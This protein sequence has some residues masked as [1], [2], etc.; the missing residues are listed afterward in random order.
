MGISSAPVYPFPGG[1]AG[2]IPPNP[3]AGRPGHFA[4]SN[5]IKQ[6]TLNL[7]S[8]SVKNSGDTMRG[9]LNVQTPTDP[10]H[11]TTKQYVDSMSEGMPVGAI[12]Q[13]AS[14]IVPNSKW[15]LCDGSPH[16]SPAL[17]AVLAG[18]P[19]PNRTP[20]LRGAFVVAANAAGPGA[21]ALSRTDYPLRAQGGDDLIFL[22]ANQSGLRAHT[23]VV[24]PPNTLT[25]AMTGN[26]VHGHTA[27]TNAGG[28]HIHQLRILDGTAAS[29]DGQ[30]FDSSPVQ[31]WNNYPP[32]GETVAGGGAHN[33]PIT[34]DGANID[35]AHTV[36][37]PA[38]EAL[39]SGALSAAEP[40][41]NRPVF[42]ALVYL[43]KKV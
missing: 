41:E 40:H 23:H 9:P 36:D 27:R 43:I 19:D 3:E 16:G 33:H 24:D 14:T 34:V 30:G 32:N 12:I 5:W 10:S 25:S 26:Q 20:D 42:F 38:F 13:F 31:G 37:I 28:D 29:G 11:A 8:E 35:H 18:S 1:S 22:S 39:N 4:W 2:V 15:H 7:D 17:A 6:F 21:P